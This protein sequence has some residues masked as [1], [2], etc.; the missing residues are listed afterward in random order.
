MGRSNG[1]TQRA[2]RP[3][4]QGPAAGGALAGSSRRPA[5]ARFPLWSCPA[6]TQ[7]TAAPAAAGRAPQGSRRSSCLRRGHAPPGAP[8]PPGCRR[9]LG[10]APRG[11]PAHCAAGRGWTALGPGSSAAALGPAGRRRLLLEGRGRHMRHGQA[12]TGRTRC[13]GVMFVRLRVLPALPFQARVRTWVL[14][15]VIHQGVQAMQAALHRLPP[16]YAPHMACGGEEA[17][18]GIAAARCTG[19]HAH[20][21]VNCA[22]QFRG[23]ACRPLSGNQDRKMRN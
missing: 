18:A 10:R 17:H 13:Y 1:A 11:R 3:T 2:G 14:V 9:V 12:T 16:A 19:S 23:R 15:W 5:V 7:G 20:L 22:L 4:R 21:R 8:A 6:G